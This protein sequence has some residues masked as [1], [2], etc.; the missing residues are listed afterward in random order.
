MPNVT[1]N[2][3]RIE[4]E[5]RGPD[6][7]RPLLL[8][9]GTAGQMTLWPEEFVDKLVDKGFRVIRYDARDTGLSE[10]M[11]AA[12]PADIPGIFQ[13]LAT[14]QTPS[15][16]YTL[17]DMA[18]DAVGLLDAL[19][20][21]KAHIVGGSMGGMVAQLVAADH[22]EHVL[23]LTSIMS[24]TANPALPQP[25]AEVIAALSAPAP[26][27]VADPDAYVSH[28]VAN[29]RI[30]Q[31]PG[32][33]ET[34]ERLLD[35][36]RRDLERSNYPLGFGRHYAAVLVAADR[37]PKLKTI[38]APTLVIHGDSDPLVP[39]AGG[40]DTA[41]NIPGAELLIIEKMGH[42]LP[43]GLFD[44]FVEAIDRNAQRAQG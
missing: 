28:M 13:A 34:D 5:S 26:D 27:P 41:E 9:M 25:T 40:R 18:A 20:I 19:G 3:I 43:S 29:A 8:I 1:A 32:Y 17:D 37:R 12:G 31:S 33:P 7:G 21:A 22:P 11:E 39:P 14:G 30:T 4:Y 42:D 16:A 24:T 44:T 2:G 35:I 10:K 36:W 15:A 6:S 38:E 23:S